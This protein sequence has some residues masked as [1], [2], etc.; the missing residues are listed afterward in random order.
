MLAYHPVLN[1]EV[2]ERLTGSQITPFTVPE[3]KRALLIEPW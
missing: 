3:R 1:S 2:E